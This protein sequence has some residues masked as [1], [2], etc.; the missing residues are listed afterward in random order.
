MPGADKTG[1]LQIT[2]RLPTKGAKTVSGSVPTVTSV[3]CT[4][5][6]GSFT[7]I[8]S[9]DSTG[10]ICIWENPEHGLL[11]HA[12]VFWQPHQGG[13]TDMAATTTHVLTIG[14]DGY[15]LIHDMGNGFPLIRSMNV[16]DW[17]MDKQLLGN[18]EIP[19]RLKCMQ[20]TEDFEKGGTLLI[21]TNYGEV[22][23]SAIGTTL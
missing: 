20:V 4:G 7:H 14:N 8:W 2:L 23:I 6:F 1:C 17:C 15:L 18:P 21:G 22:L 11:F 9:G 13:I 10:Q 16:L 5:Y 12:V 3:L 19:R